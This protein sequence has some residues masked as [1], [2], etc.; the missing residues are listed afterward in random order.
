VPSEEERRAFELAKDHRISKL[1]LI[2]SAANLYGQKIAD[3][4]L[5]LQAAQMWWG[6]LVNED[7][8]DVVPVATPAPVSVNNVAAG[9]VCDVCGKP[10]T[11]VAFKSGKPSWTPQQLADFGQ[12]KYGKVLCK[13][14][15]FGA[16]V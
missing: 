7:G 3:P 9:P 13:A 6:W 5:V 14:H 2:S 4:T 15:Y 8:A 1:S 12:A 11:E 16:K 10:L